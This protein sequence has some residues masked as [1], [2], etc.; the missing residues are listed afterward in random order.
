MMKLEKM[1]HLLVIIITIVSQGCLLSAC[2]S[3]NEA[4]TDYNLGNKYTSQGK[5]EDAVTAYQR[6]IQID[7][8]GVGTHNNL[9]Y[10]YYNQGKLEDAVAEYQRS[11]ALDPN[12]APA[13]Y[14]LACIYSLKN[15]QTPAIK[16]L[17]KAIAL[18]QSTIIEQSKTDGD[19]DNI[20][21]RAEFQ[22][23]INSE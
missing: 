15:E 7:P 5:L 13:H 10:V 9:G 1:N 3:K 19:L 23:L 14:N 16:W 8:N 12:L 17:Q 22:Q 11:I 21:Q 2:D 18:D 4:E 6:A 20:R